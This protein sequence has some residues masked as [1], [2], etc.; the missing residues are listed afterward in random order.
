MLKTL[1]RRQLDA[2][3]R[4]YRYD[5]SYLRELVDIDLG[6]FL[7]FARATKLS[8]YRRDLP[9]AVW[10]A[11]KLTGAMAEDCG[12]CSQ[13][14]VTMAERDGVDAKLLRAV[15]RGDLGALGDDV[16][17]GV[18]FARAVLERDV[19]GDALR[20]QVVARWGR[21]A[22]VSLAFAVVSARMYPTLKY[23]LGFGRTCS[24]LVVGGEPIAVHRAQHAS[25]L[26]A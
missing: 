16:R 23:A 4:D 5:T 21:Q 25:S 2:F 14:V 26:S 18:E 12:P 15:A 22:L 8:R 9:L 6:A 19:R 20:E 3:D 7:R 13:L 10:H 24:R 11:A 17:L 1:I